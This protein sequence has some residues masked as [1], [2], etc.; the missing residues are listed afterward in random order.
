MRH[1][2]L[3]YGL[4]FASLFAMPACMDE[5]E[6]V[7]GVESTAGNED[8]SGSEVS[9]SARFDTGNEMDL[10]EGGVVGGA[11]LRAPTTEGSQVGSD[12]SAGNG[13]RPVSAAAPCGLSIRAQGGGVT[14][15]QIR[16]CHGFS[17]RRKVDIA[18]WSDVGPCHTIHAGATVNGAVN[19]PGFAYLRGLKGC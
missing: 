8:I 7:V 17:V 13:Q 14:Y 4:M 12:P 19:I 6:D 5:P 9:D 1:Y 10:P 18:N 15:Y 16:N 3:S 11:A 2:V